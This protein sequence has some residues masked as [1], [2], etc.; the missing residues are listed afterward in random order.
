MALPKEQAAP[1]AE[2]NE[3]DDDDDSKLY[4]GLNVHGKKRKDLAKRGDPNAPTTVDGHLAPLLWRAATSHSLSIID[5]LAGSQPLEAYKH[6]LDTATKPAKRLAA[7]SD[8]GA[9]LPTLL[10]FNLNH[11]GESAVLAAAASNETSGDPLET[12]KRLM[13]R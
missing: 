2:A 3:V 9:Q 1:G 10:G 8:L 4:L 11:L 13:A 7:I 6:Y 5:Y 12:L